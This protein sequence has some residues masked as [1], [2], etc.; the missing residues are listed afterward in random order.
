MAEDR[1]KLERRRSNQDYLL[2]DE[3]VAHMAGVPMRTVRFWRNAGVLPYVKVGRHPRVWLSDFQRTF[4]KPAGK[5]A[6]EPIPTPGKISPAW[7]IRRRS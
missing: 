2:S 7:N 4:H 3:Q 6:Y 1:R 5:D